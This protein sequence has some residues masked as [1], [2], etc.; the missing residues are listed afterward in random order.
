MNGNTDRTLVACGRSKCGLGSAAGGAELH[1]LTSLGRHG[2]RPSCHDG[3]SCQYI[4]ID[5][6]ITSL[7]WHDQVTI[8][9]C[10]VNKV[11]RDVSENSYIF[12]YLGIFIQV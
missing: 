5:V 7:L 2:P 3:Q 4:D 12:F 1:D 9:F 8:W 11:M 6:T 10:I